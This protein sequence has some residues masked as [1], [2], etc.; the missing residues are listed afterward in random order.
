MRLRP[1][2]TI[3]IA[4]LL[5]T[6]SSQL[7]LTAAIPQSAP[8]NGTFQIFLTALAKNDSAAVLQEAD[9]SVAVDKH[10]VQVKS[11]HSAKDDPLLFALLLDI[12]AS[13]ASTAKSMNDAAFQL[14][15][16]LAIGQ[17][18][19]YL[20]LFNNKLTM[21]RSPL[22]ASEAKKVLDATTF[23]G[24]TA[25]YNAIEQTCK[26][27]LSK[28]GNPD[29]PRR[30]I[31]LISDGEDNQS[32]VTHLEAEQTAIEEGVSVFSIV[33]KSALSG[34]HGDNFLKQISQRTGGFATDK[35]LEQ[36]VPLS[37]AAI[38]AQ[39]LVTLVPAQPADRKLHSLQ[40]KSTQ[41]DAQ[42]IAPSQLFLQ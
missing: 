7:K 6:A 13:D 36:A 18:Q 33:T 26:Q 15:Q 24:A 23:N 10:P 40:I 39:W 19:G 5:F 28:S 32:H 27:K 3:L 42:I 29:K 34:P 38:N 21:S 35:G 12:S 17:N 22:S 14:F 2:S 1:R 11:V 37:L 30:L 25:V 41:K 4:L 16:R 8:D 20:V 31:V 9:L